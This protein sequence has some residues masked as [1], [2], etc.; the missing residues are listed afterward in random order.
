MPDAF[1]SRMILLRADLLWASELGSNSWPL[2]TNRGS[3]ITQRVIG[4]NQSEALVN[5]IKSILMGLMILINNL[6]LIRQT[7]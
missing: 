4:Y 3:L 2:A 6:N 5:F 1:E 7:K